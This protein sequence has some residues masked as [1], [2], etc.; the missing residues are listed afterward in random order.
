MHVFV[1][2]IGSVV[3]LSNLKNYAISA[4][5]DFS[6]EYLDTTVAEFTLLLLWKNQFMLHCSIIV[7]YRQ[8]IFE[9]RQLIGF[10]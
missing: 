1:G 7:D 9:P 2:G 5:F 4:I 6:D 8:S 10:P 3:Y